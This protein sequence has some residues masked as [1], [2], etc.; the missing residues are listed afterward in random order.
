M[1]SKTTAPAAKVGGLSRDRDRARFDNLVALVG[2]VTRCECG[3]QG[4]LEKVS[5]KAEPLLRKRKYSARWEHPDPGDPDCSAI[6]AYTW[7]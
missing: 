4:Y 7:P 1:V 3:K 2:T 5:V 6:C